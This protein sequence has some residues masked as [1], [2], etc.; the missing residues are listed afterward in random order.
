MSLL[1]ACLY[2][3]IGEFIFLIFCI[4]EYIPIIVIILI[5]NFIINIIEC[6]SNFKDDM[7]SKY[8]INL[9]HLLENF[10]Q[11]FFNTVYFV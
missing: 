2:V 7:L 4:K 6:T 10:V 11:I 9:L 1:T 3:Y 8:I 5:I